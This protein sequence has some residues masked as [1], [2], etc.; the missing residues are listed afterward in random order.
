MINNIQTEKDQDSSNSNPHFSGDFINHMSLSGKM[1][2]KKGSDPK[3]VQPAIITEAPID[4]EERNDTKPDPDPQ[5]LMYN[6]K[7]RQSIQAGSFEDNG[8]I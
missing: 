8:S 2:S 6:E 4:E 1:S 5:N 3:R 7:I